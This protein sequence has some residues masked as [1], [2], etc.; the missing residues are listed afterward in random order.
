MQIQSF[1]SSFGGYHDFGRILEIIHNGSTPVGSLDTTHLVR[2]GIAPFLV[3][4]VGLRFAG[5]AVEKHYLAFI[6]I[7][8]QAITEESL[9]LG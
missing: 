4:F 9:G 5:L 7:S 6:S 8:F 1:R 2:M 3:Y